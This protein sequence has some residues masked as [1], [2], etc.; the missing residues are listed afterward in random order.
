VYCCSHRLTASLIELLLFHDDENV[1]RHRIFSA[2]AKH[3]TGF[4][5]SDANDLEDEEG[6]IPLD[7]LNKL[8]HY[9]PITDVKRLFMEP[10]SKHDVPQSS[11]RN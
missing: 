2:F 1:P 6:P 7:V 10:G 5:M 4:T 8:N 9:G 3:L 11:A